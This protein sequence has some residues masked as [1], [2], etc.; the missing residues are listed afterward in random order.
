MAAPTDRVEV[1]A[2][3][4]VFL[5]GG[6]GFVGSHIAEAL[7]R[8]GIRVRALHR[9]VADTRHLL[10]LGC[11]LVEGDL[12]GSTES[13]ASAMAGC[14]AVVHAAASVYGG[15]PW[16]R[17]HEINVEGTGR[18]F[19]GA[20]RAGI[21][22]AVHLS[23][24]AVYGSVAGTAEESAVE[25]SDAG[26]REGYGRSKREAEEAVD[27]V[28]RANAMRVALLRPPV[29]YGERDRLFTPRLARVLRLPV[30][31][32]LGGGETPMATV[33]AGNLAEAALLA[34]QRPIP[35]GT[36]A[37]N[38]SGDPPV[39]QRQ[40]L[41]GLARHL[42]LPFRPIPIPRL[43]AEI[44]ARVG[45]ALG[46]RLPGL[47]EL[48]LR[49]VVEVASR[50]DPYGS[51]RVRRELGWTPSFSL[52]ESLARTAGWIAEEWGRESPLLEGR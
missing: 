6:T 33:Y 1:E 43:F 8:R 13:F 31:F 16:A 38:L 4:L 36:R 9:P 17:L 50:P 21:R 29:V 45:D 12:T 18:V 49:R 51:A 20:A 46:G 7:R 26:P 24:V 11:E 48:R 32:L 35:V 44:G 5:T 47:G 30:H 10:A 3:S 22:R 27:R 15:L 37:F 14:D 34:L 2:G 42:A 52:E 39:S 23:S 41:A 25:V 28:A 40:L 19:E